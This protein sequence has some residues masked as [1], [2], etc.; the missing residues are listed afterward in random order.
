MSSGLFQ[1]SHKLGGLGRRETGQPP[2][3]VPCGISFE[4]TTRWWLGSA[5]AEG[6]GPGHFILLSCPQGAE[7]GQGCQKLPDTPAKLAFQTCYCLG[8]GVG[9]HRS[10]PGLPAAEPGAK[11][12]SGCF[13][14]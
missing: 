5:V 2:C 7:D 4:A 12:E 11:L 6:W 8:V 10:P 3:A 1:S 9:G 13:Y 14:F